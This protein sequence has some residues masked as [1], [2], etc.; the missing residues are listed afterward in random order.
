MFASSQSWIRVL[1]A[2]VVIISLT[3]AASA[4]WVTIKND[5]GKAI[6]VQE[7]VIV[8]GQVRRGKA[9][10]LLAGE[11]LREFLP[12]PTVK[13]LEVYDAANPRQAAWSGD[14]G[15]KDANQTFSIGVAGGKVTVGQVATPK[16]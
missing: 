14:L 7:T 2:A 13:R 5:T 4:N 11:T 9:T 3:G 16:K 1:I 6:V 8:N 15:C 10:N 12:G